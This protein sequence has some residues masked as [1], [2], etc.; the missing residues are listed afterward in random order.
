MQL[1]TLSVVVRP[2]RPSP[3]FQVFVG[4][5]AEGKPEEEEEEEEESCIQGR[6]RKALESIVINAHSEE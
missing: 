1:P 5:D 6:R 4:R 2:L 3:G